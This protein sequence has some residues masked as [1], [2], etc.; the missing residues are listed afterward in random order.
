MAWSTRSTGLPL[1]SVVRPAWQPTPGDDWHDVPDMAAAVEALG[2]A[3]RRVWLTIGGNEL[4]AFRAAPQHTYVVRTVDAPPADAL[5]PHATM[6]RARGPFDLAQEHHLLATHRIERL[7]TKNSGGSATA[8]KL[9]AAREMSVPVIMVQRPVKPA[10][11]TVT[12]VAAVLDW[13][14]DRHV[15]IASSDR[16]V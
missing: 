9:T 1:L 2:P 3:P 14:A 16:G 6:I 4:A 7:V 15:Q 8:A 12:D 13:L 11:I 5:L 10:G